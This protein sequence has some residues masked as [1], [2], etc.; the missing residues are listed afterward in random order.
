[1]S[2]LE[3]RIDALFEDLPADP[4]ERLEAVTQLYAM[5]RERVAAHLEPA[6]AEL[7]NA[8]RADDYPSKRELVR[9]INAALH[10]ARLS[11][12]DPETHRPATLAPNPLPRSQHGRFFLKDSS[13]AEDGKRHQYY[14]SESRAATL[15]LDPTNPSEPGGRRQR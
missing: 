11:F 6:I 14:L 9:N 10:D 3:A 8:A 12:V 15:R 2:S 1:M 7:L 5:L 4:R 13:V